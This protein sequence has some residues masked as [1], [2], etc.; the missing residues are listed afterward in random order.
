MKTYYIVLSESNHYGWV[1]G[2][3]THAKA[4]KMRLGG[5]SNAGQQPFIMVMSFVS[6]PKGTASFI[7]L[8]EYK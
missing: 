7:W 5:N 2:L 8:L 3:T 1:G 6:Y 4:K